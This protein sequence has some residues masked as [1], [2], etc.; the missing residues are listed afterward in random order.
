MKRRLMCYVCLMGTV[1]VPVPW[2]HLIRAL[3]GVGWGLDSGYRR[4]PSIGDKQMSQRVP[5]LPLGPAIM[6]WPSVPSGP[7]DPSCPSV[8]MA[9][10]RGQGTDMGLCGDVTGD[11]GSI[12]HLKLVNMESIP[13]VHFLRQQQNSQKGKENRLLTILTYWKKHL[14]LIW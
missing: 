12:G 7:L 5:A 11:S 1:W 6:E 9:N 14:F 8:A 4:Q 10:C 2:L 13:T 3:G